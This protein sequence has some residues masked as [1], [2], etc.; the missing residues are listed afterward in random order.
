[1]NVREDK[2]TYQFGLKIIQVLCV[3]VLF[4]TVTKAAVWVQFTVKRNGVDD[5]YLL[6]LKYPTCQKLWQ[7]FFCSYK[8][9]LSQI[10][11]SYPQT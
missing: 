2:M 9:F 4:R 1:M 10:V 6:H 3:P 8:D 7:L 11:F 5:E